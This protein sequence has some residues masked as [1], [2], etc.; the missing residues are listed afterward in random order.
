MKTIKQ[1]EVMQWVEDN[2]KDEISRDQ[3]II[4]AA[5]YFHD[6]YGLVPKFAYC[7]ASEFEDN[8]EIETV[9]GMLKLKTHKQVLP[10]TC[11]ICIDERLQEDKK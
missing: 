2:K 9:F 4:D 7:P 11:W 8:K 5:V 10:K 6:K 1:Y 3:R